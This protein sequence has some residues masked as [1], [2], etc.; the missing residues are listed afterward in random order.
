MR[1]IVRVAQRRG[2]AP[3]PRGGRNPKKPEADPFAGAKVWTWEE[4][5]ALKGTWPDDRTV[6]E[7]LAERQAFRERYI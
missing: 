6:E 7:L 3:A 5:E 1:Y 4:F 2:A